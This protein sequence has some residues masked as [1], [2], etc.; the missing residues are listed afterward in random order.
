MPPESDDIDWEIL[1]R[2]IRKGRC[3]P[4][5]GAGACY[6]SVPLGGEVAREWARD[7]GYP[8]DDRGDL[9]RVAQFMVT[10]K[11]DKMW[12]K[13][14]LGDRIERTSPPDFSQPDEPH[15]LLADLPLPIYLTT[16]YDPFMAQALESRGR[17]PRLEIC[18]WNRKTADLPSVFDDPAG[19]EPTVENPLVFHLHGHVSNCDSMV[20]TEDD[21]FEF[22]VNRDR[23]DL[24]APRI[25]EALTDS[26]VLFL[27]YKIADLD[28]RVLFHSLQSYLD[29]TTQ[30]GH[31]SVQLVDVDPTATEDQKRRARC[32]LKKYFAGL[33]VRVH[34]D[35]CRKFAAELRQRWEG[36]LRDR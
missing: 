3:T 30:R 27:G 24:L 29:P 13:E 14:I 9:A 4:F 15:A 11:D 32:Y 36:D 33:H 5:L 20:L 12:P 16:N 1:L 10:E 28:F 26:T 35:T 19:Y 8:L 34:W 25:R 17:K 22:L 23:R 18:R 6:G 2:R 31:V 21:Y 7:Y